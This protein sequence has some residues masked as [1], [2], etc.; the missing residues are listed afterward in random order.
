MDWA[1]LSKAS[2]IAEVGP[3]GAEW[4]EEHHVVGLQQEVELGQVQDL[5]AVKTLRWS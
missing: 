1:S 5:L 4:A 2:R 3:A